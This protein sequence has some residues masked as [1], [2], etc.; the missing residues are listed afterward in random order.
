MDK[1]SIVLFSGFLE[2]DINYISNFAIKSGLNIL[3]SNLEN[4]WALLVMKFTVK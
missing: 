3:Y 1:N 2:S 4:N